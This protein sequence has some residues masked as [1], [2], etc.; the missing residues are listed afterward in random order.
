MLPSHTGRL[1]YS[2]TV[3]PLKA[4]GVP[5]RIVQAI[6]TVRHLLLSGAQY[7]S[8]ET[9]QRKARKASRPKD[10][11]AGMQLASWLAGQSLGK[12]ARQP[13]RFSS[14][15]KWESV[16]LRGIIQCLF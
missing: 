7:S 4:A 1:S 16:F 9:G 6:L 13:G 12:S 2:E 10:R 11:L 3:W 14:P 8:I 5:A 15:V